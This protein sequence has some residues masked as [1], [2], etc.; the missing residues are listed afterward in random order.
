MDAATLTVLLVEENAGDRRL[1]E[2]ALQDGE[3]GSVRLVCVPDLRQ[4]RDAL[5]RERFDAVL[6]DLWLP[7]SQGL[8]TLSAV[9][10]VAGG[11]PVLVL[12][13]MGLSDLPLDALRHGAEDFL[14]KDELDGR[15]LLRAIR[16]ARERAHREQ[17]A[18]FLTTA[19]A[20]LAATL[21]YPTTLR[22]LAH[23]LVP[24]VADWC[25]IETLQ[26]SG[27]LVAEEVVASSQEKQALLRAK[28]RSHP[29]QPESGTHPVDET[30]RSGTSRLLPRVDDEALR[31]I[32][33]DEAHLHLLRRLGIHSTL[34]VPL[35]DRGEVLGALTLATAESGRTLGPVEQALVEDLAR[36]A[37]AAMANALRFRDAAEGRRRAERVA[38][39]ERR[40]E[41][42]A[43]ALAAA[44]TPQ[45]VAA[46][47]MRE[48][49]AAVGASAGALLQLD[50]ARAAL[51]LVRSAG[52]SSESLA[53]WALRP[54]E[55]AT[56]FSSVIRSGRPLAIQ[57]PARL[58]E[59]FP[60]LSPG[61]PEAEASGLVVAPLVTDRG[62]VGVIALLFPAA[63]L[64]DGEEQE[65]LA[66]CAG[67]CAL[68]LERSQLF[69][70]EQRAR[71]EAGLAIRA[72]DEVLGIVA[73]DLRSPLGAIAAFASVLEHADLAPQQRARAVDGIQD[74]VS[75]MDRLI[76]DLLDITRID[77]GALEIDP[78]PLDSGSVLR[79][80]VLMVEAEAA[81]RGI[82]L[83]LEAGDDLP[84]A[85]ADGNRMLQVLSNLL[86]NALRF[87]PPGGTIQVRAEAL[88]GEVLVL[89][90]DSGPGIPREDQPH[91]F[92]RFWQGRG[93][94]RGGAGLGLAIAKGI[95]ERHGGRI[96]VES[97]PG[98]GSTFFF[99]LPTVGSEEGASAPAGVPV[100]ES[101]PEDA[102]PAPVRT[103]RVVLVEDHPVFRHGL[104]THLE[105][106]GA[107]EIVGQ[108]GTGEEAVQM[109]RLLRPDLVIM[110]LGLPG[111][112]GIEATRE[113]VGRHPNVRVV[114]LTG[115]QERDALLPVLRAGGSGFVRKSI[116]HED[117]IPALEAALRGEVFLC[118]SGNQ[119][120]LREFRAE[121][122][123]GHAAR[124]ESLTEQERQV[125]ALAAEGF[126]SAEIGRKLFLSPNTVD[127]YR[128]RAMRELI[129]TLSTPSRWL[130]NRS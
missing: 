14:R 45:E 24:A 130:A 80:A 78:L 84:G 89:V 71:E 113:I 40:L 100:E 120:L 31:R 102:A 106:A 126:T 30:I 26:A 22:S 51:A 104:K 25:V 83:R 15:T 65:M 3:P 33:Y 67:K 72:R 121:G 123:S 107:Y 59:A 20:T 124:L 19:V 10:E 122:R 34:T 42:L 50:E 96:G 128:S 27:S 87:T 23:L 2:L 52:P 64:P 86:A 101:R 119:L 114:A 109:A 91:L 13:A 125:L 81:R 49:L 36:P 56:P 76:N 48:G 93:A 47:M 38:H 75:Q 70:H 11:V 111:M 94:H 68:A 74:C 92:D 8:A 90:A 118:P 1:A 63:G 69:Q 6:L 103:A 39:R 53:A 43:A 58:R 99:T 105:Q 18:T 129:A 73:H 54:L 57:D 97:R 5:Q 12:S 55:H 28:L 37:A 108:A 35:L 82:D 41:R 112:S 7:D 61:L 110:D 62:A 9:L 85:R 117:L 115:E 116:A 29:R 60:D 127:S 77:A 66:E 16:H 32:A 95:V 88:D 46:V 98:E 4:A 17:R 21:D 79:Q 44:S